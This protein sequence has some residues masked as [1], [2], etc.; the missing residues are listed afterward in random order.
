V[1]KG[2]EIKISLG[3]EPHA[4]TWKKC[5]SIGDEEWCSPAVNI[6]IKNVG[7]TCYEQFIA[8]WR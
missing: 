4:V 5:A 8:E 3:T 2:S 1:L 6:S 7:E